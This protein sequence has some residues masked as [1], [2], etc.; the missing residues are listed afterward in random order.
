VTLDYDLAAYD[1]TVFAANVDN[2]KKAK[3]LQ[4]RGDALARKGMQ[5]EAK[6]T[7][8]LA[9]NYAYNDPQLNEDTRVQYH[10][11]I[12]Q[13]AVVGL[14]GQRGLLRQQKGVAPTEQPTLGARFDQAEAERV[15]SSLSQDDNVNL[16]RITTRLIQMQEM[17]AGSRAQLT[18]NV[19]LR[20]RQIELQRVLQVK[21]N[22]DML[23]SFDA[24]REVP[25]RT[26]KS[27]TWAA[28]LAVGLFVLLAADRRLA[29]RR[30]AAPEPP[31]N[32]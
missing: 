17:A 28:G 12:R 9:R 24:S 10:N 18:I 13:Q 25:P 32:A 26:R 30:P 15:Q 21:P 4:S 11:L 23:V 19:P 7:L 22:S 1:R 27:A 8:E 2:I 14:V 6:Q 3:E 29:R 20:G 16:D 5:Q 31:A